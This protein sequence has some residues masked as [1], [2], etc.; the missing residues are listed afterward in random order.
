MIYTGTN[1]APSS[2]R[3]RYPSSLPIPAELVAALYRK[4]AEMGVSVSELAA[5]AVEREVSIEGVR[6]VLGAPLAA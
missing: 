6:A 5:I 1:K 4:A 3:V 2:K